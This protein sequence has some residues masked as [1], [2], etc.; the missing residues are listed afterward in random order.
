MTPPFRH[1]GAPNPEHVD[2]MDGQNN[3]NAVEHHHPHGDYDWMG[4]LDS[5][6]TGHHHGGYS[7]DDLN[8]LHGAERGEQHDL[9]ALTVSA[10]S[11]TEDVKIAASEKCGKTGQSG[12]S[13][14]ESSDNHGPEKGAIKSQEQGVASSRAADARPKSTTGC[15]VASFAVKSHFPSY[16]A[17]E[18]DQRAS[19]SASSSQAV[20]VA[21]KPMDGNPNEENDDE[22]AKKSSRVERKRCREKQR[23]LDTNSQFAALADIVREIETRDFAEEAAGLGWNAPASSDAGV[24]AAATSAACQST[25]NSVEEADSSKKFKTDYSSNASSKSGSSNRVDLIARTCTVITQLRQIR[26]N[27]REELR[28]AKRQNF[29]MRKEIEELRRVVA[30]HKALG[31]G[32]TKPQEKVSP[33]QTLLIEE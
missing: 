26:R 10:E 23:R 31:M 20:A 17:G 24:A 2:D 16:P 14:S 22:E 28:D 3:L 9:D 18:D 8:A 33:V 1:Q 6:E 30:H 5:L 13:K 7:F 15:A 32:P 25:S 21:S 11:Q 29:E 27:R 19:S 12:G 4:I